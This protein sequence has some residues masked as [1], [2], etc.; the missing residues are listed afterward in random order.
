VD[1]AYAKHA[2]AEAHLSALRGAVEEA[3][4]ADLSRELTFRVTYPYGDDDERAILTLRLELRSPSEWSLMIGDVL[5]NLRASL[6][7]AVFGHATSRAALN[8]KQRSNLYHPILQTRAEWDGLP[9]TTAADG[10]VTEARAGV[11]EKLQDL[12][13]PSVLAVIEQHQPFNASGDVAW[14]G[15]TILS[16]LVNRDKHR[17]VLD[18]PVNIAELAM[19]DSNVDIMSEGDLSVVSDGVVEKEITVRRAVRRGGR[20][21]GYTL[22]LIQANTAFLE[23]I[24]IPNTGERRSFITVMEKLVEQ[25]GGY[26]DELKSAGC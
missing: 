22:G 12:V 4:A 2:R 26:L 10:T 6:D 24:E 15:L 13:E 1:S 25:N 8:A 14:H 9:Q 23:E 18:L 19:G 5:T 21:A 16:G 3:H 7:H 11:R 20:A 17:S